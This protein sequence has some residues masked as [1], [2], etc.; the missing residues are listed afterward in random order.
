M[1]NLT[2]CSILVLE[3]NTL[4]CSVLVDALGAV[5]VP[6]LLSTADP[7][8][9]FDRFKSYP[10]DIVIS[11]W[12]SDLNG[13][14]FLKR[15]RSDANS[16]NPFVPAIICTA[17]VQ[18]RHLH[19]ARDIGKTEFLAKP[20]SGKALYSRIVSMIERD[21]HAVEAGG[22]KRPDRRR[23]GDDA[24]FETWRRRAFND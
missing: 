21:R 9:A 10:V 13:R 5:G 18:N 19:A 22:F 2:K 14:A 24:H 7:E 6:T 16:P 3:K 1:L 20:D 8:I 15:I 12:S 23:R 4:I 11:D 17:N